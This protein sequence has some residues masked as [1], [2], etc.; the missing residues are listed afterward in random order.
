MKIALIG[1]TA[2][3]LIQF[4]KELIN[5]LH[6][7]GHVVYAFA[8]D[9]DDVTKEK[10]KSFGA[11]PVHYCFSRTGLNPFSDVINTYKLYKILKSLQL[12]LAFSYFSKPAIFG[13]LAAKFARIQKRYAMLEG[14]GFFFTNSGGQVSLRTK[15]LKKILVSLYKVSFRH[16]ESLILLNADDK[17]DLLVNEKIQVKKV[18]ILGGIGLNMSD[19]PY[20]PP[21]VEPV[22]FIFVARF[23][24]EKGVYEF[25]EAAKIVKNKF[26]ETHFC[27]LGHLDLHNPGSLTIERLNDLK[28]NN[29][30]ELPGHVDNVQ[31]WLAKASVF[32]LPS[33]REGFPRSTQEAM[34]MGRAVITSD[35][36]GCRDTV[37]DGVNG[38]LIKPKSAEELADK[39]IYFLNEPDEIK[40]MGEAS[41][42]IAKMNFDSSIVNINLLS[43]LDIPINTITKF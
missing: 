28:C 11:I 4:R 40:K 25:I 15:L 16:I 20:C 24:Q 7:N 9:Y 41:Y 18:H 31:E 32:V 6:K 17:R 35:V 5:L 10:V 12:D 3:S 8:I 29:I 39:M 2:E 37:V 38:F 42:N 1:T 33:W 19:Y 43:I 26:P 13:T 23:L 30:I 36:P 14:L 34:A 27:M 21:P 22:S